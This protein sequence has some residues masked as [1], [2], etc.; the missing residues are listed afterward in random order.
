MKVLTDGVN[1]PIEVGGNKLNTI[2]YSACMTH[3]LI[4]SN[5]Q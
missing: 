2:H 3:C 1:L 4:P 5:P